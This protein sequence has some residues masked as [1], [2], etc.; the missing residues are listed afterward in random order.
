M[1]SVDEFNDGHCTHEEKKNLGKH[2]LDLL[3]QDLKPMW[4]A[5]RK[6]AGWGPGD[7]ADMEGIDSYIQQLSKLDPDSFSFR[8]T[9]SKKGQP[10]LRA[11]L[12]MINLRH[13]AEMMERLAD[14]LDGFDA[15][16]GGYEEGQKEK[17]FAEAEYS[18]EW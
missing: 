16:I 1:V 17:R 3:W 7:A 12:A 4:D 10:L 18:D 8:Y 15:A 13:F 11:D 14:Y 5:L 2:R 9:H 6:K